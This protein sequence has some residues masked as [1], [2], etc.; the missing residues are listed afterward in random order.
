[1]IKKNTFFNQ[2]QHNTIIFIRF[3]TSLIKKKE[4]KNDILKHDS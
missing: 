3:Y 1:M 2:N 4:K